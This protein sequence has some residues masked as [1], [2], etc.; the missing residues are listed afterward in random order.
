MLEGD[1]YTI[2]KKSQPEEGGSRVPT[3]F[4]GNREES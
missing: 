1:T 4:G 2:K 3:W